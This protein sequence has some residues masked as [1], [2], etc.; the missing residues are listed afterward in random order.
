MH[1]LVLCVLVLSLAVI[2]VAHQADQG[3][4][5]DLYQ[6]LGLDRFASTSARLQCALAVPCLTEQLERVC[7]WF[8]ASASPS[9]RH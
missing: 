8:T 7:S 9:G 6:L 1:S 5:D 2:S 3:F 4:G